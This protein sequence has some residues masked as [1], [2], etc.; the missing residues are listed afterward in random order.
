MHFQILKK[1]KL[2]DCLFHKMCLPASSI[3]ARHKSQAVIVWGIF[4]G[5]CFLHIRVEKKFSKCL[6]FA[7]S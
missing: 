4:Y 1:S 3:F 2:I 5:S 6:L 7:Q